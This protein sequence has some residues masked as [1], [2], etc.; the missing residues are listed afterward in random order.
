MKV[1]PHCG[2]EIVDEIFVMAKCHSCKGLVHHRISA[3]NENLYLS[4]NEVNDFDDQR[5]STPE[6]WAERFR[7]KVQWQDMYEK[8]QIRF[9]NYPKDEDVFWAELLAE[10]MVQGKRGDWLQYCVLKTVQAGVL[11]DRKKFESAL[12]SCYWVLAFLA[13]AS[14]DSELVGEVLAMATLARNQ[15]GFS[16]VQVHELFLS[17]GGKAIPFTKQRFTPEQVWESVSSFLI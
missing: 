3:D 12:R 9:G 8:L 13:I 16:R 1:C 2:N 10:Q 4:S 5:A 14:P 11:I 15:G 7:R 6:L 17:W